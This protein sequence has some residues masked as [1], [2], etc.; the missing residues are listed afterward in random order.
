MEP[1]KKNRPNSLVIILF[2]LIALMIIIYFILVMF[3]PTVFD[4]M[5]KGEIQPVPNK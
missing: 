2:A 1:K 3:F 4:L 5:N